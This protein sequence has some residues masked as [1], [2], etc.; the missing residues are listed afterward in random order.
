MAGVPA[1]RKKQYMR[2]PLER[3]VRSLSTRIREKIQVAQKK[4]V[5]WVPDANRSN[6]LVLYTD[7]SNTGWGFKVMQ[8]D[9]VLARGSGRWPKAQKLW[10]MPTKEAMAALR[11]LTATP[12][13]WAEGLPIKWMTD[14][15][16]TLSALDK[17]NFT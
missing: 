13:S 17:K 1:D 3:G 14:S 15:A 7:A 2:L 9:R 8:D 5:E 16:T 6:P 4:G 10:G 12:T 11:G